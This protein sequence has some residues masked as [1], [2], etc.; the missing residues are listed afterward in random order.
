MHDSLPP[1]LSRHQGV[2]A[3]R[4]QAT[5]FLPRR[6]AARDACTGLAR[7]RTVQNHVAGLPATC[8]QPLVGCVDVCQRVGHRQ[9]A[10][11]AAVP[12]V[13]IAQ[14]ADVKLPRH[15]PAP[16]QKLR[17][18]WGDTALCW[19][20]C[21]SKTQR[22]WGQLSVGS[23]DTTQHSMPWC[24]AGHRPTRTG[25]LWHG[26]A[27]SWQRM[28]TC[29]RAASAPGP[30]HCRAR[31]VWWAAPSGGAIS[32]RRLSASR[33]WSAAAAPARLAPCA[34]PCG[35]ARGVRRR[36]VQVTLLTAAS[37]LTS[38]EWSGSERVRTASLAICINRR[39]PH[40]ARVHRSLARAG[41]R[42]TWKLCGQPHP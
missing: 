15:L 29:K 23:A 21:H 32:G 28:R 5:L 34:G 41:R 2:K 17:I 25:S 11:A 24:A 35:V 39:C 30:P 31:R 40:V 6:H 37:G 38:S 13:V 8:Q 9:R 26:S 19:L 36:Q 42:P 3:Q 12:A 7:R 33:A 14:D 22:P 27:L 4:C 10:R 1:L 18:K 20:C 16:S